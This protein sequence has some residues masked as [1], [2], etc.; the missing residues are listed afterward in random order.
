MELILFF[1]DIQPKVSEINRFRTFLSELDKWLI[2]KGEETFS[3]KIEEEYEK[4]KIGIE[5]KLNYL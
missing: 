3:H 4:Y 5:K 2:S 1:E